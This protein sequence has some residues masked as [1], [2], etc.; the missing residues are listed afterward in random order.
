MIFPEKTKPIA[1]KWR[2]PFK[3][4][5]YTRLS[6]RAAVVVLGVLSV[7]F[8]ISYLVVSFITDKRFAAGLEEHST[9]LSQTAAAATYHFDRSL[10]FLRV[11]PATVANDMEVIT[12]LRSFDLE[13][14]RKITTQKDKPAVLNSAS[15]LMALNHHLAEQQVDLD[16]NVIWV[17]APNGDCLA[18]SNYNS[19][20]SF[21]GIS[22]A[23]RAYFKSAM[24]GQQGR[25]YAVGRQTN[26]PGL[27]FSAPI[28]DGK[29]VIG[30]VIVKIDISKFSQ[31]LN[32]FNCFISNTDGVIIL[33]SEGIIEHH[34][35]ID[36]PVFRMSTEDRD[37]KYKRKDFPLLNIGTFGGKLSRYSSI[38][39]PGSDSPYLLAQ[40]QPTRDGYTVF[41]YAKVAEM[42]LFH[43]IRWQFTVLVFISGTTLFLLIGGI[44][45]YLRDMRESLVAAQ[46]ASHAKSA[47]LANM[48]HEI[49][50][51][52][53]AIIGMS[54][55][56]LQSE[57]TAKQREQITLL[58]SAAE[59][60]LAIINDILD[61][62]KVEAGKMT[63]EQSPFVLGDSLYEVIE[64]Q[65][66]K[67]EE[68]K[69]ALQYAA[70]DGILAPDAPLLLGDV[71]RLR[72]VLSNLLSNAVKFTEKG[73]VRLGVSSSFV[74]NTVRV[75]FTV[76]DSGIGM[77]PD[78]ITQ[79]FEEF[80]QADTSTTRQYGGTGLGMAIAARL[81][82]L[83]GGTIKVESQLGLGSCF[84]VEIPFT[85]ALVGQTPLQERRR[86]GGDYPTL[87]GCRVL[88]VEDN[89]VNRL[90]AV[91]L[92]TMQGVRTDIAENGALA[93]EKLQS[94]PPETFAAV[95]MD[96]QMPVLD[97][98]EASRRIRNDPKFKALP[99]IALSAHVISSQKERCRQI[100]MNGY[101][102]KPFNPEEL[103]HTLRRALRKK[104]TLQAL[105]H[106]LPVPQPLPG[107]VGP[108]GKGVTFSDGLRRAG[109]DRHLYAK[110]VGEVLEN[111]TSGYEELLECANQKEC[112]RG[113]ACA[114]KLRGV[115]GAIGA[116]EMEVAMASI[117]EAFSTG[118]DPRSQILT[119]EKPYMAL[120][121]SLR[122]YG[123]TENLQQPGEKMLR[124]GGSVG[125]VVWLEEFAGLLGTGDFKAVE[126][127]ENN[128]NLLQGS[129]SPADLE[130]IS[131]ALQMFDFAL[132]LEYLTAGTDR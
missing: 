106:S 73:F 49:R 1:G 102:N 27:F 96:L 64:L 77:S 36:A 117:E 24:V 65:R 119:L 80:T 52:M 68:K 21:I 29:T 123:A 93:V 8:F 101:I 124:M 79:L 84:T 30:A 43:K 25:Q 13:A 78:Q 126:L 61:F 72:Q 94:L 32:R 37:R 113:L 76:E 51:P 34:A 54:Y 6:P 95:L 41:T 53:N 115:F 31:W 110:V 111:F 104:E 58:H 59:S 19:P 114:H 63:L 120:M 17:L 86:T 109:G 75:I 70:Q 69:L 98:Y 118:A 20:E 131:K 33:A 83:M 128:K 71:L 18:S 10:A 9:E 132:A 55:L 60:L 11:L 105:P 100:G 39:L 22:Y 66:P 57:L 108:A 40:S 38:N 127:W 23:D 2:K 15:D 122:A 62:S 56:A 92:L 82:A 85:V 5:P 50:T 46:A 129:F 42:E 47:F 103:W 7:W 44:R 112:Q 81:V 116:E 4:L 3:R 26:I 87:R 99:I 28:W 48:S 88:L 74:G 91:E 125:E 107:A 89:P 130:Q 14:L 90:L 12:A 121:E 67:I 97:G 35:L 16:V 45:L